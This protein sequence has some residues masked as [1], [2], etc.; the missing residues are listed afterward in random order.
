VE[1]RRSIGAL[2]PEQVIAERALGYGLR[3]L[4]SAQFER[5]L[6][7][8][9]KSLQYT[10]PWPIRHAENL[11]YLAVAR[12]RVSNGASDLLS[13]WEELQAMYPGTEWDLKSRQ[14][15]SA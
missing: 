9:E 12:Y 4:N 11:Y 10:E 15:K 3:W 6:Q 1:D 5:S 13:G 2:A 7:E 8:L 14:L